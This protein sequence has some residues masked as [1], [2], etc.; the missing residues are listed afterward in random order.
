MKVNLEKL[1][2]EGI[3]EGANGKL[4]HR[5]EAWKR[6]IDN[7]GTKSGIREFDNDNTPLI[8]VESGCQHNDLLHAHGASTSI[9]GCLAKTFIGEIQ[10]VDLSKDHLKACEKLTE[11]YSEYITY[12]CQDSV[13][14]LKNL[15]L[16]KKIDLL[17][18]DSF[19]FVQPYFEESRQHCLNELKAAWDLLE[20]GSLVVIDDAND[21]LNDLWHGGKLEGI[22]KE[23]KS[24]YAHKYLLEHGAELLVDGYMRVYKVRK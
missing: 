17:L 21:P 13:E 1:Y 10:T 4:E 8:F 19:D 12:N 3:I 5:H 23:G 16:N 14:F 20:D 15:K 22:D 24:G 6:I 18:L 11:D 9:L 2:N 7:I